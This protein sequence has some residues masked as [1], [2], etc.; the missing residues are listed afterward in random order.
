MHYTP[1]GPLL[2][3]WNDAFLR[4]L[5]IDD[6]IAF[7]KERKV[8]LVKIDPDVPVGFGEPGKEEAEEG[9]VGQTF[10]DELKASGWRYS[11]EQIQFKN[12]AFL[13]LTSTED[14]LLA[15]MK[16]KTR[17]NI[18]LAG[19]KGVTVREGTATDFDKLYKMYSETA[20]RDGFAIRSQEYY[21]TVW[22][23]F[24]QSD[25]LT[26][27]IA[28]VEGDPVAGLMLFHFGETAWYLY[29][30]SRISHREKMPNYLLQWEAIRKAKQKG[31][32]VYDLWGAPDVFD[33]SDSLWGVYRFK[34]G[35][36]GQVAR[37]IG[38][39]DLPLRPWTYRLYA[40]VWPRIMNVLRR[41]GKGRTQQ[42]LD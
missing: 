33:E 10:L 28:E 38:A 40:Q 20:V 36:G 12:T 1:K 8:F 39:W 26:P 4:E 3:D 42:E 9:L 2:K 29:G 27:L 22:N 13:D 31:C 5:V 32:R 34:R 16:Q 30:M 18:R 19:R 37:H 11:N 21:T 23:T 7:A 24:I 35:L 14:D 25:M 41:R 15:Q 17:Y 6:L